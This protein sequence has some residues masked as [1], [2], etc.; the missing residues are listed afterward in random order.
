MTEL[1]RPTILILIQHYLPGTNSGG[2]VRS[3][4]NLVETLGDE[5]EFKVL[6]LDRDHGSTA[7]YAEIQYDHW[8]PVGKAL[9]RYLTP[10]DLRPWSLRNILNDMDFDLVYANGMYSSIVISALLL[11]RLHAVKRRPT[12]IAPRGHIE[13]GALGLKSRKKRVFLESAKVAGLY[14]QMNWQASSQPEA[15]DIAREFGAAQVPHIHII[16]NLAMPIGAAPPP[17]AP[18]KSSGALR[19]VFLSRI[20]RK[21]NLHF[22]LRCLLGIEG[23]IEFSIY[24]PVEDASYWAECQEF[25]AQLPASVNVRYCG[26]VS[27]DQVHEVLGGY[28][29]FFLPTLGENFGHVILEAL[30]AGCPVLISDRTPWNDIQEAGAGWV[31][32]LTEPSAFAKLIQ[33]IADMDISAWTGFRRCAFEFATEFLASSSAVDDTRRLLMSLASPEKE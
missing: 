10:I 31:V 29:L 20:S 9:V 21:K 8:V 23:N 14:H 4:S 27:P 26:S 11:R 15:E 25:I 22:A 6:A 3:M 12:V 1:G 30:S 28:H 7:P 5:F 32:P 13:A 18:V 16:P 17:D 19:I 33:Q 24:G 2:P